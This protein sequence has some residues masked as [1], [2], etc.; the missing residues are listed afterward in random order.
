MEFDN[1]PRYWS[2]GYDRPI[3]SVCTWDQYN[4]TIEMHLAGQHVWALENIDPDLYA[5]LIIDTTSTV[6][7]TKGLTLPDDP[8]YYTFTI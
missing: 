7:G 2:E 4:R 3:D 5:V 6:T 8:G 1:Y